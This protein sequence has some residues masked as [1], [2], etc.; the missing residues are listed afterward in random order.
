MSNFPV[1]P[2]EGVSLA[3]SFADAAAPSRKTEQ[4]YELEA[5]R[6]YTENGWKIAAIVTLYTVLLGIGIGAIINFVFA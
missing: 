4:Y 5:N 6:A 3:Y 2:M 1:K